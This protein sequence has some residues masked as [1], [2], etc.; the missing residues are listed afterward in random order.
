MRKLAGRNTLLAVAALA[1]VASVVTGRERPTLEL[2]EPRLERRAEAVPEIDLAA[3]ERRA[4]EPSAADQASDP[5]APRSFEPE[6]K[7]KSPQ[8]AKPAKPEAPP[9]PFAYL[10]RMV[11]GDKVAVFL[12]RGE[13]SLSVAAG[14]VLGDYRV[15]AVTD[16]EVR[17]TYLPMKTKQSLPL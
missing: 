16:T 7:E 17:F 9:L 5:F 8:K 4:L 1:L 3:L 15:D 6:V 12:S 14:D 13:E 10:G 11:D 2:V